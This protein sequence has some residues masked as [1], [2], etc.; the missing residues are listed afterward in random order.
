MVL[1][2]P[3]RVQGLIGQARQ[4]VCCKGPFQIPPSVSFALSQNRPDRLDHLHV[5][6]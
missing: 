6:S 4:L 2:D 1:P 3:V 5:Q